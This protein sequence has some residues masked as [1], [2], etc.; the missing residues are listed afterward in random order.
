MWND[1][2]ELA[3]YL[4]IDLDMLDEL[5][6]TSIELVARTALAKIKAPS[7]YEYKAKCLRV[8]DGD[9][10]EFAVDLGFSLTSRR[11]IRLMGIDT[12][13]IRGRSDA[14]EEHGRQASE[15]VYSNLFADGE[16]IEVTIRTHKDK[17]EKYGR[18][19]ADVYLPS[20]ESLVQLL[21]D[22]GFEKMP[23]Y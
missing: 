7:L 20:G 22:N 13:E 1:T 2:R 12:P 5:V 18:Y 17:R 4:D 16:A 10:M 14:E 19:M 3:E 11:T 23:M 9:T 6:P 8:I 15:F 21:K